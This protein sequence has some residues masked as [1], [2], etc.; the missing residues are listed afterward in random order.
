MSK[1]LGNFV[2][3]DDLVEKYG[4]DQVRYF[5]MRELPFGNDGNLSH[6]AIVNRINGDLTNDLGNLVQRVLSMIQQYCGGRIP[7]PGELEA[8]DGKL[9]EA[10]DALLVAQRGFMERQEI[11]L[12]LGE[13]WRVI[14]KANRYVDAM[15]PWEL[16]KTDEERTATVLFVLA[17]SIRHVAVLC[18][19]FMPDAA[20]RILDQLAV[21]EGRR[22]FA[23]LGTAGALDPG[24]TLPKPVGVFPRYVE[25]EVA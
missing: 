5:L 14:G 24:T 3:P 19:P 7:R 23:F 1:S 25:K 13:L 12:A 4:L 10:Y 20:G 2:S 6:R 21:E 22:G 11:H 9:L 18:Q 16:R 15:A 8:D 17:E